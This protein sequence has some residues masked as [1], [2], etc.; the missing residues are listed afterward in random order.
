VGKVSRWL[1]VLAYSGG[2][3][4]IPESLRQFY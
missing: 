3:A 4:H 1:K 2:S